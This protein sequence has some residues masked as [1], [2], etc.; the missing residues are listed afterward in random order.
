MEKKVVKD[1]IKNKGVR[2]M[3]QIKCFRDKAKRRQAEI[4]AEEDGKY[5]RL[6]RGPNWQRKG[7]KA[8]MQ[9]IRGL[10]EGR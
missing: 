2:G 4:L 5:F 7:K 8:R 9:S 1:M 10:V 3:K 6:L